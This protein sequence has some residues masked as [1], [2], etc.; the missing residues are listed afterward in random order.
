MHRKEERITGVLATYLRLSKEDEDI[1]YERKEESNS[2]RTQRLLL[3]GYISQCDD[4]R[5]YQIMEYVD[6]GY[7]GKNFDRPEIKRLLSDVRN[8]RIQCIMVKDFSRFGRDY[9]EVGNYIE[10]VF[11]FMG[12]RF[13]AVNN[14]FDSITMKAGEVPDMDFSFQNLIY[15]YYSVENSIKTKKVQEKR[16]QEGKYMSVYAPYGYLKDPQDNNHLLIDEEAA[17][18]IRD[19]YAWYLE[20]KTKAEIARI[21]DARKVLTPAEY[22]TA[23]GSNYNW[24]YKES[25][26]K[27]CGAIIGRILRNRIYTGTLVSGKT[28]SIEIGGKRVRYKKK[29]EWC[30]IKNTHQPI[31]SKELY[32]EVQNLAINYK[33][34]K[35]NRGSK[36]NKNNRSNI[37]N[38]SIIGNTSNNDN[39]HNKDN[40]IR[41]VN[42]ALL[43]GYLQCGGCKHK[44]TKRD[45]LKVSFYCR[46]YYEL[47]NE[48]CIRGNV[49]QDKIFEVVLDTIRKQVFLEDNSNY[50]LDMKHYVEQ[51]RERA[52]KNSRRRVEDEMDKLKQDNFRKYI[53]FRTGEMEKERYLAGKQNNEKLIKQLEER[54]IEYKDNADA[55][56]NISERQTFLDVLEPSGNIKSLTK[57]LID[58]L[59]ESIEVYPGNRVIIRVKNKSIWSLTP[60]KRD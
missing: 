47:H 10:K 31:I 12:I 54:Y 30:S 3:Q 39:K 34:N 20:G 43:I 18:H 25:Q 28:E 17:M 36:S 1:L 57:D 56:H 40:Y 26:G 24:R 13:I 46:Y 58:A 11:P 45:R 37:G 49:Y 14:R 22:M 16:R 51:A 27:W 21:L 55:S 8:N 41:E 6:D 44:L 48:N 7:S 5:E 29:E 32:E 42:D 50:L 23:K 33:G 59:I 15:D 4:L 38:I 53:L 35:N 9:V 2:I 60:D 52:W 19:I